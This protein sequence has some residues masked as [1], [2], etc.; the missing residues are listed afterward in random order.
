MQ[1]NMRMGHPIALPL[2]YRAG[3]RVE[4]GDDSFPDNV[5]LKLRHGADDR[6]HGLPIGVDL[7]GASWQK[8]KSIP[9]ARNSAS[10]V[11]S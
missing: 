1:S 6:E 5:L 9:S 2:L 7:S 10:A 8:T 3:E 11:T 4:P